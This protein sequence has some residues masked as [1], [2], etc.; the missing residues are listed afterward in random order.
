MLS[1]LSKIK[2]KFDIYMYVCIKMRHQHETL[3][4]RWDLGNGKCGCFTHTWFMFYGFEKVNKSKS[5]QK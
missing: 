3:F 2:V 5:H 4:C 1:V